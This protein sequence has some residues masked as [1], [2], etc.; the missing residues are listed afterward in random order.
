MKSS[1]SAAGL[2]WVVLLLLGTGT[3]LTAAAETPP[4]PLRDYPRLWWDDAGSILTAPARWDSQDWLC[5]SADS[6]AVVGTAAL[7]DRSLRD[8]TQRHTRSSWEKTVNHFET[9]GSTGSFVVIGGFYLEGL[10]RN[11]PQAENT[12][13]DALSASIVAAGIITPLLKEATGRSRPVAHQGLH[14]FKPFSGAASFPSGHVTQA[15]AVASVVAAHYDS[16]WVDGLAY[17]AAG[18]VG[19]ARMDHNA[20][21]ASDVLAGAMIGTVVGRTSVRMGDEE[22][23]GVA[24]KTVSFEPWVEPKGTGLVISV[25]F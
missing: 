20:H 4:L 5:F 10:V 18:L 6:A 12:A 2:T 25:G 16:V 22:R 15:F 24:G 14:H 8:W 13:G 7:L 23:K 17:A 1:L 19:L 9:L 3:V 11:D 21:F